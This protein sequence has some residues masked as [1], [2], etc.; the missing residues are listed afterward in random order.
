MVHICSVATVS[1]VQRGVD[2]TDPNETR[3]ALVLLIGA[4]IG[5]LVVIMTALPH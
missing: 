1:T 4:L 2:V 3:T 5:M